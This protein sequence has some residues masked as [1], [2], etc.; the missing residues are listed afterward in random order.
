MEPG[1]DW[2]KTRTLN[3]NSPNAHKHTRPK[4]D[5]MQKCKEQICKYLRIERKTTG[6]FAARAHT[7]ADWLGKLG[8]WV[9]HLR[10][11][12]S[13]RLFC[14]LNRVHETI[15]KLLL[16]VI[17]IVVWMDKCTRIGTSN[18]FECDSNR[19][20]YEMTTMWRCMR[21]SYVCGYAVRIC[22]CVCV[23]KR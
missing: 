23:W 17:S 20:E 6:H 3:L 18:E 12:W 14:E 22:V 1:G 4:P 10:L 9:H 16:S 8:K 5:Q 15:R 2:L 21:L 13:Y 19:S 7:H 11:Y